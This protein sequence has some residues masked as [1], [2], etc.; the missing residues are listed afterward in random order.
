MMVTWKRRTVFTRMEMFL[1]EVVRMIG[2]M[3]VMRMVMLMTLQMIE[4]DIVC[5]L[6]QSHVLLLVRSL[7][8]PGIL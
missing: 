4:M 5:V 7:L 2:R 3:L 8:M 1:S 6:K